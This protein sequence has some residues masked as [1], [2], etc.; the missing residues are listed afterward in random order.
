VSIVTATTLKTSMGTALTALDSLI[1]TPG[2]AAY[3]TFV[4]A[5]ATIET[6]A[7][8]SRI[9]I[10]DASSRH[11]FGDDVRVLARAARREAEFIARADVA[12][13]K[14]WRRLK[15]NLV[16]SAGSLWSEY[17]SASAGNPAA[18]VS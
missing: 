18:G 11:G 6:N 5:L 15:R 17:Q 3:D 7:R 16:G 10:K 8:D 14:Q 9:S 2:Q 1:A 12:S 13:A 4:A